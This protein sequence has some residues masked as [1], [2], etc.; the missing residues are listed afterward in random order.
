VTRR[1]SPREWQNWSGSVACRPVVLA[2]PTSEAEVADLVRAAARAGQPVRVAATG[3]SFVP[4]C[5]S[6]GVLLS[7]RG[8]SGVVSADRAA[9]LATVRAGSTIE[10]L[11]PLLRA[12]GVALANMGDIDRQ[13][14]AGAISTGTHGT[15]RAL[16]NLSTQVAGLRL[17][18]AEGELVDCDAEHHAE[19][20]HCACVALGALGVLTR[21]RLRV[22]PAYRL[23]ERKWEAPFDDCMAELDR[24]AAAT[25]HFEF[26][27]RPRT[28]RCEMKALHPTEDAPES[29][30]GR[31][32]E[33]IG[34]S[35][36]IFPSERNVKFNE[37]EFA[38]PEAAGPECI[39]EIRALMRTRHPEV[40]WP[41]EY[42][43][44]AA[45]DIP[46][47]PAYRRAT[48]TIS[49]HQAAELP[50]ADFFADVETVFRAHDGRPHWGKHHSH[51]AAD[52][53]ALYPEWERFQSARVRVDPRGRFLNDYLGRLLLGA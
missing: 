9:G 12:Q 25:R 6:D 20:F 33:R 18:T 1:T 31:A 11:G 28:D 43:T 5:A 27:W 34:W 13:G 36:E 41:L 40:A 21:V 14:I 39:R 3:H 17:V 53:R 32:G 8:L 29:V 47:S 45:D 51:G 48:V 37:M 46:L 22:L 10:D 26:F 44:L 52:L 49:V 2:A 15:G 42:R 19:L 50:Y 7:L 23:H 30:A 4:L 16:G 35:D 24:H 38:V